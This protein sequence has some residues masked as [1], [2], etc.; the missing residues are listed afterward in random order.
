MAQGQAANA[1]FLMRRM[2]P[3]ALSEL[4]ALLT[5]SGVIPTNSASSFRVIDGFA[6]IASMIFWGSASAAAN[7]PL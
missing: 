7:L 5:P 2:A 6:R 1:D 3:D 4:I